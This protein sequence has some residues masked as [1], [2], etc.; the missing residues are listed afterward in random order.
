MSRTAELLGDA[1][2]FHIATIDGDQAR[3][4]PFGFVMDFEGKVYFTTGNGK[5]FYR[6]AKK[7]PKVEMSAMLPDGRWIRVSGSA[8]FDGNMAAK[9]KAFEL[10]DGFK[11]I[12]RSP[13]GPTF[14]VF[15]LDNMSAVVYSFTDAPEKII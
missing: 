14:E 4:R 13:D 7:N 2:V 15:Y 12:Y 10:Y 11:A 8:V 3:V 1:K 9:K 6:Q 5:D